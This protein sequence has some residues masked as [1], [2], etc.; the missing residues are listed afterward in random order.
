MPAAM[1]TP[2]QR[3]AMRPSGGQALKA[4]THT[5]S[6][7]STQTSATSLA[8]S[9][10]GLSSRRRP[11][12]R[13]RRHFSS[14]MMQ[15][16]CAS[17]TSSTASVPA[18]R[19]APGGSCRTL[20]CAMKREQA[21][22]GSRSFSATTSPTTIG[23]GGGSSFSSFASVAVVSWRSPSRRRRAVL[24][25]SADAPLRPIRD[26]VL[27]GPAFCAALP[28]TSSRC[29]RSP[30]CA[31]HSRYSSPARRVPASTLTTA[32]TS[33]PRI[34]HSSVTEARS[35]REAG[36][37]ACRASSSVTA[38]RSAGP[39][40]QAGAASALLGDMRKLLGDPGNG[41]L[42]VKV[43]AGAAGPASAFDIDLGDRV[44]LGGAC[45]GAATIGTLA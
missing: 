10:G 31:G 43:A 14:R 41:E 32:T 20:M 19:G 35:G 12:L 3:K 38:S 42:S 26:A 29:A 23:G 4:S 36:S 21:C 13:P 44:G 28:S 7:G 15:R 22:A 27:P 30:L 39:S 8:S 16:T 37:G 5:G 2:R 6:R 9:A 45:Q 17:C 33:E 11:P 34:L 18:R 25:T 1:V 24:N 40:Y